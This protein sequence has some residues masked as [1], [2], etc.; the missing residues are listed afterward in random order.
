MEAA[1]PAPN[2][3]DHAQFNGF[4]NKLMEEA[5]PALTALENLDE[6]DV[7][8]LAALTRKQV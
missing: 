4:G 3:E 6:E 5:N 8:D 2:E 1:T 7:L